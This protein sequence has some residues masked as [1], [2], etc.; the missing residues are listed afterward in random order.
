MSVLMVE[1]EM[2][3]VRMEGSFQ[4]GDDGCGGG[5]KVKRDEDEILVFARVQRSRR[6]QYEEE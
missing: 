6:E 4:E 1:E 5:M 2:L 3:R